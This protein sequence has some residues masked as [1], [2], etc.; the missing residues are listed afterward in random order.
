MLLVFLLH[1]I[2]LEKFS[3]FSV[4]SFLFHMRGSSV[5]FIPCCCSLSDIAS[6]K[7][8]WWNLWDMLKV[9]ATINS[10]GGCHIWLEHKS[11]SCGCQQGPRNRSDLTFVPGLTDN[12]T[13]IAPN[14]SRWNN[15]NSHVVP[16]AS[17]TQVG[18]RKWMLEWDHGYVR[19]H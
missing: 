1:K 15:R 17:L 9:I 8:S 11:G 5:H 18:Q 3:L 2:T 4:P 10:L 19:G 14:L 12:A 13:K 6:K 7:I 16:S